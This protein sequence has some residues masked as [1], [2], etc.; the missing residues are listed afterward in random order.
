MAAETRTEKATLGGG[1]FWCLEPVFEELVGVEQVMVG[2]AGGEH[3]APDYNLVC[4]GATGHAEVIQID[5][6]P[7][8][9]NFTEL[10]EVFFKL[11]F[12]I[13]D[14]CVADDKVIRCIQMADIV[15]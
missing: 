11:T 1:C 6:D 14:T 3:P 13:A 10:L 9:L 5:F 12:Y 8:Q 4:S 7:E 2:Y 15:A